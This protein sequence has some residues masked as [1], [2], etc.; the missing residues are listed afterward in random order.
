MTSLTFF[1]DFISQP[2]RAVGLLLGAAKIEHVKHP[3]KLAGGEHKKDEEFGKVCPTRE[4][5][6]ICDGDFCLF[7]SSSIL[8][9]LVRKYNL[10]EHWYP[11]DVQ[12]Q[13]K[14]DEY[15]GWHGTN[16]RRGAAWY[17]ANKYVAPIL[18]GG[19]PNP[20]KLKDLEGVQKRSKDML[21]NYFLKD[22]KFI[23]GDE[24][25]IADLQAVCEFT[26]FWMV[27]ID[28]CEGYPR[29]TQWIK[30]VQAAIGQ[31]IFDEVHVF[32]YSMRDQNMFGTK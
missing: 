12:R 1:H 6:A 17:L 14:I 28:P 19:T 4:V 24:I 7:E 11:S 18:I 27:H 21:E 3:L 2:T 32:V 15:L 31:E 20:D 8:K 16:L 25:C 22:K 5:P 30:D 10:P 9:Y 26:Q 29:I 13:A 23:G